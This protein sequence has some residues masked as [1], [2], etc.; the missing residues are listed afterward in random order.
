MSQLSR[1]EVWSRYWARGA[2]HSCATTFESF[3]RPIFAALPSE[4]RILDIGCGNAPLAQL[5]S[6]QVD[7][8]RYLG[9][10]LAQ[11]QPRWLGSL[12]SAQQSR[13]SLLG[14]TAAEALPCES[15][16]I[17][18]VISQ[19]GLEY[20]DLS[21]SLAELERV[22]KKGGQIALLMHHENSL[23]VRNAH[24]ELTHLDHLEAS[25]GLLEMAPPMLA[26]VA[27]LGQPGGLERLRADPKAAQIRRLYDQALAAL[28]QRVATGRAPDLL[29]EVRNSIVAAIAEAP[30][31]GVEQGTLAIARLRADLADLRLRLQELVTAARDETAIKEITAQLGATQ[32]EWREQGE[33]FGWTVVRSAQA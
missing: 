2:L 25:T 33:L 5:L 24:D 32:G 31:S 16:S 11:P 8:P 29:L 9:V 15:G 30:R 20:S 22:L 7:M 21:R 12:P 17:D 13:I 27:Q 14:D 19:Y 3:W 18:L 26:C 23:P 28:D 10:D 4:A 1:R 6:A